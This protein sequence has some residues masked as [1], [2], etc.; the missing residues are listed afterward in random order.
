MKERA[1][2]AAVNRLA[3]RV[4]AVA[5]LGPFYKVTLDCGFPLIA[6]LT[7]R[8]VCS[9][10][11]RTVAEIEADAIHVFAAIGSAAHAADGGG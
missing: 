3:A 8:E 4:D 11:S 1:S 10:G 5:P 2:T 9:L 6:H 7:K